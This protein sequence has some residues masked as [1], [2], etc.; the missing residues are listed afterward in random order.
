MVKVMAMRMDKITEDFEAVNHQSA[1]GLFPEINSNNLVWPTGQI[2]LLIGIHTT[3]THPVAADERKHMVESLSLL[4]LQF[5]TGILLDG[6]HHSIKAYWG[7]LSN[8]THS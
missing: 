8:V 1:A 7:K 2:T 5:G 4:S 3:E 6:A